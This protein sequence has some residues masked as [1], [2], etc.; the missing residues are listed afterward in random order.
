MSA[1]FLDDVPQLYIAGKI[2][3]NCFRHVVIPQLR[4]HLWEDG[5]IKTPEFD[6][7]GPFFV[8][9]DHG[10]FHGPTTHGA[11]GEDGIE[12][13]DSK[14][15][16]QNCCDG[17]ARCDVLFAYINAHECY[18]TVAEIEQAL[19]LGKHVVL[20][21]APGLANETENEFWFVSLRANQVYFNAKEADLPGL[22]SDC[23]KGVA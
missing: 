23:L 5:P 14:Q 1:D 22:L 10:C 19:M 2:Q 11:L 18:G 12:R 21:F 13:R 9:C 7:V 17:V 15:V 3:K 6:Y 8:G 4:N 16:I 20:A